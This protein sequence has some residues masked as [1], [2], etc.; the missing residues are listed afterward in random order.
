MH[1]DEW[2][3]VDEVV[4][5]FRSHDER[6]DELPATQRL[7]Q[8][9]DDA[10]LDEVDD[11]VREHLRMNAEAA[12]AAELG[13]HGVRDRSD[14]ELQRVTVADE[15]GDSLSDGARYRVEWLGGRAPISARRRRW[16]A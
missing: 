1:L 15:S 6:A 7:P 3:V 11:A 2:V 13:E 4:E 9:R 8:R 14:A 10:A 12:V 5:A 16:S